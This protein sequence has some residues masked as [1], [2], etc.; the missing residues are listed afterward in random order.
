VAV[1]VG[2]VGAGSRARDVYA[3]ALAASSEVEFRAVWARSPEPVRQLAERHGAAPCATFDELIDRCEAVVLAVPPHVLVEYAA[4]AA[5]S[6]RALLL[7]KPIGGDIA[8]AEELT[9]L[10]QREKV[11]T[12][13]ALS[14]RFADDVRRFLDHEAPSTEP[15]GGTARL[16]TGAHTRDEPTPAWRRA[17][18]VLRDHAADL[19]D[20]LEAALG[21]IVGM[22]AHGEPRGW[23]G[24]S[25]DHQVGRFSEASLYAGRLQGPDVAFVEV[26]GPQGTADVEAFG[27]VG[28]D[29]HQGMIAEFAK[30]VTAGAGSEGRRHPLD[31]EHGLH[32]QRLV[33]AAETDLVLHG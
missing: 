22:H 8:G 33:E 1:P 4:R 17:R 26:T 32:L 12:M 16:L 23:T 30:V 14:W 5:R 13:V 18:G 15:V 25:M 21:P 28:P 11:P 3:P 24:L 9:S 29:A 2:L 31:I 10:A 27:A 19:F 20:L 7:E 6:H